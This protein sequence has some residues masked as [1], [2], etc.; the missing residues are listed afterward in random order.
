MTNHL[1]QMCLAPYGGPVPMRDRFPN[2]SVPDLVG[3]LEAMPSG[4][5]TIATILEQASR[6]GHLRGPSPQVIAINRNLIKS[7][8]Q[9]VLTD[10]LSPQTFAASNSTWLAMVDASRLQE[11]RA[12]FLWRRVVPSAPRLFSGVSDATV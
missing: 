2:Q 9:A 12:H 3:L 7:Q 4:N 6:L 11:P 8:L 5:Y 10:G 1:Q